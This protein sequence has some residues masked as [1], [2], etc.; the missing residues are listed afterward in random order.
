MK[1]TTVRSK[2]IEDDQEEEA[3]LSCQQLA[4]SIEISIAAAT[5][6]GVFSLKDT[7]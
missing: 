4:A 2:T 7:E 5:P 3:T 6:G 1:G